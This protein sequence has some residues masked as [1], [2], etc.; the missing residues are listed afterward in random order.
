MLGRRDTVTPFADGQAMAQRWQVAPANLFLQRGG[1]FTVPLGLLR[2][3][4][5]LRRLAERLG[6]PPAA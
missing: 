5:P 4:A 1:H 3:P 6:A 2:D